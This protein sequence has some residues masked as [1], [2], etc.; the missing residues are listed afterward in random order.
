ML[1][2]QDGLAIKSNELFPKDSGWI[3]SKHVIA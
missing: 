3:S 1:G 2:L